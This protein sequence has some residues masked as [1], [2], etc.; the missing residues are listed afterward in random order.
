MPDTHHAYEHVQGIYFPIAVVVFGFVVL[1]LAALLITGA[2]RR[3]PS[4]RT[5]MLPLEILYACGLA[6]VAAFLVWTTFR[7]ETPIDRI[8]ASPALRIQVTAAQWSWRF[9]YPN[10]LEVSAV[11]TWHPPVAVV[12]TGVPVEFDGTSSDVIHGFWVPQLRFQRQILPRYVTRFD[13]IFHDEG[14]YGG[15]C[16]VYCGQQHTQMHF[17]LEAVSPR[18]FRE[19][20]A[21]ERRAV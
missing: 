1:A 8:V 19:W 3:R 21:G 10:G 13:L 4:R 5:E 17:E 16:A 12:P 18:V 15:V 9:R 6:A 11:A 7:A 20:L 2:R 14:L